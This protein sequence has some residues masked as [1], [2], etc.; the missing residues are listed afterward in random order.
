MMKVE[1]KTT[2]PSTS[3]DV[4]IDVGTIRLHF[5]AEEEKRVVR[6]IDCFIL[7]LVGNFTLRGRVDANV[8]SKDV[9][10]VFLS[11]YVTGMRNQSLPRLTNQDLDKQSLSYASVFG[12]ID[13]LSLEGSEYSWC[14]SLF[15]LGKSDCCSILT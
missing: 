5:S 12:L 3:K 6:K 8:H 1:L 14:S 9:L 7:P 10:G 4:S 13:D 2:D 15:Y 11:M